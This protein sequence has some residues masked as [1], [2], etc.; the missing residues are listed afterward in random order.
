VLATFETGNGRR[1]ALHHRRG[2]R[3]TVSAGPPRRRRWV[4]ILEK[5]VV[6]VAI[7][8]LSSGDTEDQ[9]FG[10]PNRQR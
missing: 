1:G 9:H 10:E 5:V 2:G 6:F 4:G 7:T 3:I 8:A